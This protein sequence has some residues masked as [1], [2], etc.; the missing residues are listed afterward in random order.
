MAIGVR[1]VAVG[2]SLVAVA[3]FLVA[4]AIGREQVAVHRFIAPVRPVY[5]AG[6]TGTVPG[7]A[8][9]SSRRGL[10]TR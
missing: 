2:V 7:G 9:T 1:L 3:V 8:G 4:V 6:P 5:I 10:S